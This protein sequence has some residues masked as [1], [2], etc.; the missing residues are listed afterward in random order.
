M[1]AWVSHERVED[2]SSTQS[3]TDIDNCCFVNRQCVN[4]QQ[5]VEGYW[6]YQSNE[7]PDPGTTPQQT[8]AQPINSASA[9]VNNCCF[10]NRHCATDQQWVDGYWAYQR[11]ECT[12]SGQNSYTSSHNIRIDGD[13]LFRSHVNA[14]LDL[15]KASSNHWYNYTIHGLDR[16]W[17]SPLGV[18]GV[19]TVAKSFALP[20]DYLYSWG[21]QL[22]DDNNIW[23]AGVFV[24]EACHVY[25]G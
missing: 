12:T 8:L 20:N 9:E 18:L 14:A 17:Q 19:D 7:C 4:Y 6:A 2:A 3:R 11:H 1:A 21:E 23:M 22:S 10:V 13:E 15:I 25:R 24:H 16:I 5:W